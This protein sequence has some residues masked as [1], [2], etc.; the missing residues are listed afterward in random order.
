MVLLWDLRKKDEKSLLYAESN[1]VE[2][3]GKWNRTVVTRDGEVGE[4]GRCWPKGTKLPLCKM[5]KF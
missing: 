3:I 2:F 1:E 5:N 4:I